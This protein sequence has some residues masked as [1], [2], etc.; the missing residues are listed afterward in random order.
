MRMPHSSIGTPF[1][2]PGE[3]DPAMDS[4]ASVM[5]HWFRKDWF[6]KPELQAQ[7][8]ERYGYDLGVPVNWSAYEDI[9]E[10]FSVHVKEIDGVRVYGHMDY[11]KRAPDLGWRMTVGDVEPR[12][13]DVLALTGH[14]VGEVIGQLQARVRA[15]EVRIVDVGVVEV[16]TGLHLGLDRLD[17]LAFAE[18]LVI[19]LDAGD[20][21]EG[22]GQR[23][24]LVLVSRNGLR[25]HVDFHALEG[26]GRLDEPLHLGNLLGTRQLR[27]LEFVIHPS[28]CRCHVGL[29]G[30]RTCHHGKYC[31]R[32]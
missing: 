26:L 29:G 6:D 5:R 22:F 18:E 3:V 17:D 9:A 2:R 14:E 23:I 32:R 10:F 19:H 30:A 13:G 28:L 27:G 12:I 25:Q 1:G 4:Q 31:R 11:G 24:R 15:D 16:T 21:L 8:K 7:F 20:L